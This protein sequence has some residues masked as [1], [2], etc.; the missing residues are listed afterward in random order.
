[1]TPVQPP[2]LAAW[3]LRQFGS[4]PKNESI[5]GDLSERFRQGRS[6][7]WY[8]RQ[9]TI[10]IIE[11][12]FTDLR[13]RKLVGLRAVVLGLIVIHIVGNT[14]FNLFGRVLAATQYFRLIGVMLVPTGTPFPVWVYPFFAAVVCI[15][16][17]ISGWVVGRLHRRHRAAMVLLYALSMLLYLFGFAI[18]E[19]LETSALSGGGSFA[20]YLV[21]CTV[22]LMGILFGGTFHMSRRDATCAQNVSS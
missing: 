5:I 21:N 20:F 10:A 9:V 22:V 6:R 2:R 16:G 17:M 19:G 12:A 14:M 1:M 18:V 13:T 8:W 7:M 11:S 4:S 3:L 15:V